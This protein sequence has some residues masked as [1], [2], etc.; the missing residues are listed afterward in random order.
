LRTKSFRKFAAGAALAMLAVLP[1]GALPR[2]GPPPT[3]QSVCESHGGVFASPLHL[4][5]MVVRLFGCCDT[6]R[7]L[8]VDV[9]FE[10][11]LRGEPQLAERTLM[12]AQ[13]ATSSA[14]WF[15]RTGANQTR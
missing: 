12:D 7:V 14:P 15:S 2:G 9:G 1:A 8:V 6:V 11:G 10:F 5:G 3:S 13:D 4:Q